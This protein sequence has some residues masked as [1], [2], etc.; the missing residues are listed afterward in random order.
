MTRIRFVPFALALMALG[1]CSTPKPAVETA[2]T[3]PE[4][5]EARQPAPTR[6][7]RDAVLRQGAYTARSA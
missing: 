5:P 2:R 6:T 1:A 4:V 3:I 7:V